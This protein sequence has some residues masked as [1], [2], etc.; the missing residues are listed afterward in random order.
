[1]VKNKIFVS[2]LMSV[3]SEAPT[4]LKEAIDSILN[5]TFSN[6]EFFVYLDKPDNDELWVF[7]QECAAKDKRLIIHRN[8][9]NR[10]LAGTLNDELKI[11]KG[12]YIVRMDGDD[13]SVPYRIE[14]LV[15]YMEAHPNVGVASS[16]MQE[17]G[18][19]KRRD[20]RVVRYEDDFEK[21]KVNYLCQTPIAHAPCIIRR[22]VIEQHGPVLYNEHCS[23]TQDYELWSRLIQSGVIFGMVSEPLYLRR[24]TQGAGLNPIKYQVIHNQVCR[25]NV[26]SVL[27]K[28]G[29]ELPE[30]IDESMIGKISRAVSSSSGL[31]KKQLQMILCIVY[32]NIYLNPITRLFK[33]FFKGDIQALSALSIRMKV[34]FC[35][36]HQ[37]TELN[38]IVTSPHQLIYVK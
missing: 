3:Y 24:K 14:H 28:V 34:Y 38:N 22:S 18:H 37:L 4:T 17:F 32:S 9:K 12:D 21:M 26:S 35:L 13:I 1:M 23:K 2:V 8:E 7:L 6:L 27:S 19:K 11:A 29:I 10:F 36:S 16:W 25:R 33:M 15:N 5:Q 30:V 31:L 20:N